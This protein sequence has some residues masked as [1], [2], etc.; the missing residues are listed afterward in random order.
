MPHRRSNFPLM[1][2]AAV[3]SGAGMLSFSEATAQESRQIYEVRTYLLGEAGD[4]AAVD[5]YLR[6]ALLPTLSRVGVGPVGVFGN[7]PADESAP[8]IVVVIPYDSPAQMAAAAAAVDSDPEYAKAAEGYLD[9]GPKDPPYE[10]IRSELLV[11][12]DCMKRAAVPEGTLENDD[13][14]YE[15]RVYES[16][17]E[18]LGNLKVDM[19]NSGE[20]P[21]FLD[22]GI[23]PIFL[24]QCVVGPQM[25][26]LTYLTVY[27][28]EASR[29]E[30]WK[31]FRSHPDWEV[32]SKDPKYA[33]TVSRIDKFVL[34]AKPYSQ[35]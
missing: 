16:A 1:I 12:M 28:D 2:V 35:M 4:E 11:A 34:T 14:V 22:C 33:G 32:L 7:A 9:R 25:P 3:F 23:Q 6:D 29:G 27:P 20:V 19:F 13:R 24:G 5:G 17:N 21:I 30:A 26:S 31:A 15:L 18:R 8:R 10:R